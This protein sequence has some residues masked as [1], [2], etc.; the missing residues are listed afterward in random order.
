MKTSNA[1]FRSTGGPKLAAR[2]HAA[3]IGNIEQDLYR[4]HLAPKDKEIVLSG[5][6][7]SGIGGIL[8]A[9]MTPLKAR[10]KTIFVGPCDLEGYL[11][12]VTTLRP[13]FMFLPKYMIH[14]IL[15][16]APDAD[17]TSIKEIVT[18]GATVPFQ[19]RDAWI[20]RHGSFCEVSYGLTE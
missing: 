6:K 14:Q 19:L 4:R 16:N 3:F 1:R 11:Q 5:F 7:G 20:K 17:L 2:T 18:G 15:E 9:L 8:G 12:I 10:W 13:T